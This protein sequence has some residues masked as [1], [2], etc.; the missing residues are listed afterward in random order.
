[1]IERLPRAQ[2]LA[3]G[4]GFQLT[5]AIPPHLPIEMVASLER[6]VATQITNLKKMSNILIFSERDIA[7]NRRLIDEILLEEQVFIS[8]LKE[9]MEVTKE[10]ASQYKPTHLNLLL[11]GLLADL[12]EEV[13][14]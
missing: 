8:P 6:E 3:E 13:C 1:M 7:E 9:I 4:G 14:L 12:T 5:R 10:E 2:A 11:T